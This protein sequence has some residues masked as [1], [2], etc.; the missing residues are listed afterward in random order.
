M[1][2]T[3]DALEI[4]FVDRL[5]FNCLIFPYD[6]DLSAELINITLTWNSS[7]LL[8]VFALTCIFTVMT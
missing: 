3:L 7:I 4:L 2:I 1:F 6:L 8:Q 5:T